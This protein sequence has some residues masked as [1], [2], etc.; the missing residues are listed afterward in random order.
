MATIDG[1]LW[2][3]N[4]TRILVLD[5]SDDYELMRDPLPAC[6]YPVLS[7]RWVLKERWPAQLVDAELEPGYLYD[8]YES[9]KGDDNTFYVGVVRRE[10][11]EAFPEGPGTLGWGNA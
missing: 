1:N 6:C 4:F 7:E 5:V 3:L 8:W 11:A 10:L 9:V 2:H